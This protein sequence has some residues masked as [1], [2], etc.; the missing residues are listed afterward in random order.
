MQTERK[1]GIIL[2]SRQKSVK[3]Q[4]KNRGIGIAPILVSRYRNEKFVIATTR[5]RMKDT[6]SLKKSLNR[7]IKRLLTA[8]I[9][10]W[11]DAIRKLVLRAI[12]C[13][14][15]FRHI[16]NGVD[17]WKYFVRMKR[18]ELRRRYLAKFLHRMLWLGFN[19]WK[20]VLAGMKLF[21]VLQR[22]LAIWQRHLRRAW[23]KW[24]IKVRTMRLM[25]RFFNRILRFWV[26]NLKWAAW[27]RWKRML[28]S[29]T[30]LTQSRNLSLGHCECVYGR[31]HRGRCTFD[32]HLANRIMM[33]REE[34][35][36]ASPSVA[37]Q[38]TAYL[39]GL[40]TA[41]LPGPRSRHAMSR[42]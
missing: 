30:R 8:G 12:I 3:S 35:N 18:I 42:W 23:K 32:K 26:E 31:K 5:H 39:S 11:K 37:N 1:H 16:D 28:S 24:V 38:R 25:A 9:N 10:K 19:K 27:S 36:K 40:V 33:L 4:N 7:W 6:T 41:T 21:D 14:L 2:L 15:L 22:A 13:R 20:S 34:L 17:R 29:R